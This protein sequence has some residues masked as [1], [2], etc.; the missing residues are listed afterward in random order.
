MHIIGVSH[1]NPTIS[2]SLSLI[3]RSQRTKT[4][5]DR[6][7]LSFLP[8]YVSGI[9]FTYEES[10]QCSDLYARATTPQQSVRVEPASENHRLLIEKKE[11]DDLRKTI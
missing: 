3:S 5:R 8:E 11:P 4:I 1:V 7:N 2:T 10:N 9:P 6:G